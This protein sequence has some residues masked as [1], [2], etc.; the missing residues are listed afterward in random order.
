MKVEN[1]KLEFKTIDVS[2]LKDY[3]GIVNNIDISVIQQDSAING[4]KAYLDILLKFIDATRYTSDGKF[5]LIQTIDYSYKSNI[6]GI[7]WFI[8]NMIDEADKQECLNKVIAQHNRNLEFELSHPNIVYVNKKASRTS[9]KKD[10]VSKVS[11]S[12][13]KTIKEK[14]EDKIP[15]IASISFKFKPK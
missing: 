10:S 3:I 2:P 6:G 13:D 1:I 8:E 4:V 12:K 7:L 9:K 15:N 11:N 5:R 14:L